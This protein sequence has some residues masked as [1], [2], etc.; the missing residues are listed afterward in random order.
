MDTALEK[1]QPDLSDICATWLLV[2]IQSFGG[3]SST[4]FL[5]HQA[6]IKRGWLN[7]E[8]FVRAWALAQIAPGIN[9]VKLTV[10]IGYRLRGWLGVIAAMAGLLLPSA[11]VTILMTAG[12]TTIRSV[13]LVEA[14]M[15]GILPAA[16][17]L[18][19]AMGA[20]MAQPLFQRARQEGRARLSVHLLILLSAALL[21]GLLKTS[22]V[23][24]LLLAGV[25]AILLFALIPVSKPGQ[26]VEKT[27]Q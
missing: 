24:V 14:M 27:V 10:M 6:V 21:M 16:I 17:G 2:G 12:F 26:P 7:E 20:Q 15:K 11:A 25:A 4:F 5:I 18:S 1:I 9:L 3:G 13:P 19:L 23:V 22:P 8:E